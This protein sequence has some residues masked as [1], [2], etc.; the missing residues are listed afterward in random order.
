MLRASL[1]ACLSL[2]IA[3]CDGPQEQAGEKADIESGAVTGNDWMRSGPAETMGARKDEAA[4]AA[5]RAR[6]MKAD[7]LE[8]QA[9]AQRAA[10]GERAEALDQQADK[11]R[12]R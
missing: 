11:L 12:E 6:D 1:I 4:A 9:D 7:A 3:A 8:G 10:A 5:R 2:T